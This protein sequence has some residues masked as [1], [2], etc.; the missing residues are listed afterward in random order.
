MVALVDAEL[1]DEKKKGIQEEGG[2]PMWI[3]YSPRH[4]LGSSQ[5]LL[6]FDHIRPDSNNEYGP[7]APE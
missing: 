5:V 6:A 1:E 2:H 3:A 7:R 4:I